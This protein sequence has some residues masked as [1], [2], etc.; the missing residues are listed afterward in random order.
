M[1]NSVFQRTIKYPE[2]GEANRDHRVQLHAELFLP[3]VTRSFQMGSSARGPGAYWGY[4]ALLKDFAPLTKPRLIFNQ[5]IG[6]NTWNPQSWPAAGLCPAETTVRAKA[7]V[8]SWKEQNPKP[9]NLTWQELSFPQGC[10][11]T[12]SMVEILTAHFHAMSRGRIMG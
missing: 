9:T 4:P 10:A 11:H 6:S 8:A 12:L 2:L 3:L 7:A 5:D 1:G